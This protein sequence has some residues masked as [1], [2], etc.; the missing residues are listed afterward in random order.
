[1]EKVQEIRLEST[2][3]D[4]DEVLKV[5]HDFS[6]NMKLSDKD[7]RRIRLLTEETMA[8]IRTLTGE[9]ELTLSFIGKDDKCI[10]QVETDTIM[11]AIKKEEILSMSSSGKNISAK[12]IMGKIRDVFE[13]AIFMPT[14]ALT[15]EYSARID[16]MGVPLQTDSEEYFDS[17]YWTLSDYKTNIE[18]TEESKEKEDEW[19]EL[20]KSIVSNVAYDVQVGVKSGHVIMC[21]VYKIS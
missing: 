18:K 20:E 21:I 17:L 16:S 3:K 4:I 10:I 5:A 15:E 19:D 7:T 1:M 8:M 9:M 13:T 14:S 6:E 12:G 2:G 11:N